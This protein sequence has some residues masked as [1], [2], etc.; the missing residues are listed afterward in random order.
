MVHSQPNKKKRVGIWIRVSTEDQARGE[1]P[2][3]HQ[4]RAQ[5]YAETKWSVYSK[6]RVVDSTNKFDFYANNLLKIQP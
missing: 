4:Q 5:Y 1:S 2:E 3:H 6:N